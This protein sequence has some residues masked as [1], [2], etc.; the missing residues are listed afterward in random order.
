MLRRW[1]A[2]VTNDFFLD[3]SLLK[4]TRDSGCIALFS[5]IGSFDHETLLNFK[6]FHNAK[7]NQLEMVRNCLESGI[8]FL[9]GLI[10]D[11][12]RR[13][14]SELN[15]E[16]EFILDNRICLYPPF[17]AWQ[18]RYL[19]L[20]TSTGFEEQLVSA[21]CESERYGCNHHHHQTH[22]RP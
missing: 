2:L 6:K 10:F 14:V 13:K 12:T 18:F 3:T 17:V 15:T 11:I 22:R 21:Q 4:M 19:A 20:Q 5:G 8:A 9:Y 1:G 16:L 7:L